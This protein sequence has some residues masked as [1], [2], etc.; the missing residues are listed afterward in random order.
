MTDEPR[1]PPLDDP[2]ATRLGRFAI[3]AEVPAAARA[4]A[5]RAFLDTAGV[6]LAGSTEPVA[7]IVQALAGE[8]G[9]HPCCQVLGTPF[10]TGAA[11]AALANGAA[12][13]ALD[14]DDMCFVSLAHPSAALVPAAF[15][16]GELA[17]ASGADVLDAHVVGFEIECALGRVMNPRH[18]TQGWHCTSTIGTLGA[19]AAAARLLR[20]D[21]EAAGRALA[22]AASGAAGLKENFGTMTKPLHAGDAARSGVVAALLARGGLTA[23]ARAIDGPQGMLVAMAAERRDTSGPLADL[24]RRWEIL[25]TGISVKLYPSCAGTHPAL[26][27]VLDL[28]ERHAIAAAE[29]DAVDVVVDEVTP[30]ILIYDRPAT[31]LEGKFSLHFCVAA[32]LV[33]GKVGLDTFEAGPLR[34]PAVARLMA[35]VTMRPDPEIGRGRPALTEA[36]VSIRLAGGREVTARASGAR[37]QHDRPASD[38]ELARKFEDCAGRALDAPAVARAF[39]ALRGIESIDDIRELTALMSWPACLPRE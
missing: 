36:R 19:A 14:Y 27:A 23:S 13:H 11:L 2:A 18:Y 28:R 1:T 17:G 34:D 35:R 12:A 8:E 33:F 29:V 4:V 5:A 3:D 31:G 32:A 24:G 10:R 16:A 30:T 7:R 39:E 21:A 26:D 15:A 25:E 6:T 38:E 37:G 9:G 22:I 20:L